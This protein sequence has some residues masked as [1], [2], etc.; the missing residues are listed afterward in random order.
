MCAGITVF[1][2]LKRFVLSSPGGAVGKK[3]GII[4][5][6]GLGH[7]ALQYASKMGAHVVAI[8]RTDAKAAEAKGFGAA[9]FLA[10]TDD[11]AMAS[12]RGTFDVLL[13]TVSGNAGI[14]MYLALL[15][16]R[17]S[18]AC[19]GL[20]EKTE[21]SQLFLHSLVLQEKNFCG[22]YLGPKGD[23]AEMLEFS[24]AHDVKPQIETYPADKV[25]EAV[26]RVRDNQARY[27]CV[28]LF[29]DP[30]V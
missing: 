8:S 2:P 10:S 30:L 9:E 24:C 23:Y 26:T 6:G 12:A 29:E 21:K 13:N 22:S 17:G 7:L 11:A 19:V 28:L 18:M 5:I 4:G 3:V 1:S 16:P 14:D 20:P 27:R 25:N 15:K